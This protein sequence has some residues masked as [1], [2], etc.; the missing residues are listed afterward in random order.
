MIPDV[1]HGGLS[2]RR[3]MAIDRRTPIPD[4][5]LELAVWFGLDRAI[6]SRSDLDRYARP[7]QLC[8]ISLMVERELFDPESEVD[9][10][11]WIDDAIEADGE[12]G[13]RAWAEL[14]RAIRAAMPAEIEWRSWWRASL[15]A[16]FAETGCRLPDAMEVRA[17]RVPYVRRHRAAFEA[18]DACS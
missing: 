11:V 10:R 18:I 9:M 14:L 13:R 2:L 6:R 4:H 12:L 1:A 8:Y 15:E 3:V 17:E 7:V 16:F 5:D